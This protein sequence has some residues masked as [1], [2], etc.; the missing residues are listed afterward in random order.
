MINPVQNINP[1]GRPMEDY[2]GIAILSFIQNPI[3]PRDISYPVLMNCLTHAVCDDCICLMPLLQ[4]N[5]PLFSD[6]DGTVAI[7]EYDE[8][9]D[10]SPAGLLGCLPR[11]LYSLWVMNGLTQH[12]TKINGPYSDLLVRSTMDDR[13]PSR[14]GVAY[15]LDWPPGHCRR[16][17]GPC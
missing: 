11:C 1:Y 10:G 13:G 5:V 15:S 3:W 2:I 8:A 6:G 16:F 17:G 9:Y 7:T 12:R 4:S 14:E